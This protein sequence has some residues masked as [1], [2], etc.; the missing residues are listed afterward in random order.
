MDF[1][2]QLPALVGVV[3]GAAGS[4]LA[5]SRT[6]KLRW[7]RARAERWDERRFEIYKSY[8]NVLKRFGQIALRIGVARGFEH[9]AQPLDPAEGME[10]L[11]EAE[12]VRAA[13]WEG[14]LL[15][16]DTETIRAAREWHK[17]VWTLDHY[18]RGMRSEPGGWQEAVRNA[19]DARNRF[20]ACARRDLGITGGLL[21][22]ET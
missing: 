9:G 22:V 19:V 5:S 1:L 6:D 7:Q 10:A 21:P 18:A 8:A 20:Y 2:D 17:I 16:A 4:Y 12:A 13:E 15:V 11:A 14:V 3:V